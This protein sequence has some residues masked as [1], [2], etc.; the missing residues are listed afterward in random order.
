MTMD[1]V[2]GSCRYYAEYRNG[3]CDKLDVIAEPE[4]CCCRL[5]ER[6]NEGMSEKEK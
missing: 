6:Y 2:C 1:D 4:D 3:F 5:Y